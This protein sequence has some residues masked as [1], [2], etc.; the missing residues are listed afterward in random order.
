MGSVVVN[1]AQ[2]LYDKHSPIKNAIMNAYRNVNYNDPVARDD[3]KFHVSR[4]AKAFL[5]GESV[6]RNKVHLSFWIMNLYNIG[7]M[8]IIFLFDGNNTTT[9]I[10][11][12]ML[13]LILL[14]HVWKERQYDKYMKLMKQL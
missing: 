6:I 5:W 9:S 10:C 8:F 2:Y 11:Q 4:E 12:L 1:L 7:F 14:Y 3:Y 13:L